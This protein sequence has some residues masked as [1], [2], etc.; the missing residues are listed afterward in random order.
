MEKEHAIKNNNNN[1]K[2][3]AIVVSIQPVCTMSPYTIEYNKRRTLVDLLTTGGAW[4][5]K[6]SGISARRYTY[7]TIYL[8]NTRSTLL[9]FRHYKRTHSHTRRANALKFFDLESR[10][11]RVGIANI[12]CL[13]FTIDTHMRVSAAYI[14]IGW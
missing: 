10:K 13:H 7:Y 2:S 5:A 12:L 4:S 11:Q 14:I 3:K 6:A 8:H 1:N 9:Y